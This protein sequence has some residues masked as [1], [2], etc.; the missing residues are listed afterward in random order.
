ME[1]KFLTEQLIPFFQMVVKLQFIN[2]VYFTVFIVNT[3]IFKNRFHYI[4]LNLLDY[5]TQKTRKHSKFVYYTQLGHLKGSFQPCK[6]L[7][8]KK[9]R[10]IS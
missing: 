8:E 2:T 5:R 10:K 3:S 7:I 4:N 6:M 1:P 9:I